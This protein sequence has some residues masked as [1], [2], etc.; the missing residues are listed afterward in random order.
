M[1][2]FYAIDHYPFEEKA[3]RS[4]L[5]QMIDD[6]AFGRIW[7][8][9]KNGEVIGYVVVTFGFSL[10]YRGR[11]AFIDEL[12]IVEDQRN[13]GV[14]TKA[15]QFVIDNCPDLGVRALHLEVERSNVA[16][17]ALYRKAGFKDHERY[18]MTRMININ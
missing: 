10:E 5:K 6:S 7:L 2:Q 3:A 15:V 13:Q 14:G 9:A 12:F 18:L 17:Q 1:R 16:A 8:I 4:T 11:D